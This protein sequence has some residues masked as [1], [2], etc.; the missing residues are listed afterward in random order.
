MEEEWA[1]A[2]EL[3]KQGGGHPR[4]SLY[5]NESEG[6]PYDVDSLQEE[7]LKKFKASIFGE[8]QA[9]AASFKGSREFSDQFRSDL[10]ARLAEIA[11]G[12]GT[13]DLAAEFRE[14]LWRAA[15]LAE[16]SWKR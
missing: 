12:E 2:I 10:S 13:L 4:V 1:R 5:F 16:D 11:R 3:N 14:G 6:N 15:I 7:A 8:C 9:L